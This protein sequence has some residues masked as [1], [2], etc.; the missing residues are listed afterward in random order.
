MS[1]QNVPK[2]M[3]FNHLVCPSLHV[4]EQK[5]IGSKVCDQSEGLNKDQIFN[6]LDSLGSIKNLNHQTQYKTLKYIK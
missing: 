6:N 4:G 3:Q 1:M 2:D 5:K